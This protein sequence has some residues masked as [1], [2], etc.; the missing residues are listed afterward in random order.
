MNQPMPKKKRKVVSK[1]TP[2]KKPVEHSNLCC[3]CKVDSCHEVKF[4]RYCVSKV[5]Q[6]CA[7]KDNASMLDWYGAEHI[8][9]DAY[10]EIWRVCTYL[11][12]EYYDPSDAV[13]DIPECM[14]TSSFMEAKEIV[15]SQMSLNSIRAFIWDGAM[16]SAPKKDH[17]GNG[18]EE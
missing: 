8:Y 16:K 6:F 3:F 7:N 1:V 12:T 14:L 2:L 4:G 18:D 9:K 11:D 15:R 17:L 5:F 10:K 13:L